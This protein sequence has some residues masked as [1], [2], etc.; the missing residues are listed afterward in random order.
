M[1]VWTHDRTPADGCLSLDAACQ[2]AASTAPQ[3]ESGAGALPTDAVEIQCCS[4]LECTEDG[5][6]KPTKGASSCDAV[7]YFACIIL[8]IN[9]RGR[10]AM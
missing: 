10:A 3:S 6:C 5:L 4:D 2:Q 9:L 1:R 8:H 7:L